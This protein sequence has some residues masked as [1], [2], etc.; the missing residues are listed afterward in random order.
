V[1]KYLTAVFMFALLLM[2]PMAALAVETTLPEDLLSWADLGALGVAA[3]LT[4]YIVQLLKLP[5][6]KV[7]GHVPTRIVVY[8]I[9]LAILI[10]AQIFVPGMGGLT[11]E[12]GILCAFNGVLVALA[13]MSTYTLTI[14]KVE[15]SKQENIEEKPPNV[16]A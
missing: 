15:Q 11:W 16:A 5:L 8:F 2:L 12:T 3:G 4:V 6:D 7:F 13:A 9:S 14:E 10:A 1:K